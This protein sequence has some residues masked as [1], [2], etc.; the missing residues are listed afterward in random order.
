VAQTTV[1]SKYQ[2]VIPKDIREQ[3]GVKKGQT[4]RVITKGGV[5]TLVPEQPL[6]ELIG[7]A[8]HVRTVG[9]RDKKDRF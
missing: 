2:L 6:S 5:I 8:K 9:L 4:F 7:F 3:T 1:S